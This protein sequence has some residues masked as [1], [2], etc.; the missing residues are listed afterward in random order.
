MLEDRACEW[1][2]KP[3]FWTNMSRWN[4]YLNDPTLTDRSQKMSDMK[5][6]SS[7]TRKPTQCQTQWTLCRQTNESEKV[8]LP[9]YLAS[10]PLLKLYTNIG[11]V[12]FFE[13]GWFFRFWSGHSEGRSQAQ[14]LKLSFERVSRRTIPRSFGILGQLWLEIGPQWVNEIQK[15][16][17]E[18]IRRIR[19]SGIGAEIGLDPN[20]VDSVT[21]GLL[22][23]RWK[24]E[25]R[26]MIDYKV[27][28][29]NQ[30]SSTNV[31]NTFLAIYRLKLHRNQ[32]KRMG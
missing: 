3:K 25:S 22:K 10:K 30:C 32:V 13:R 14:N 11:R 20:C 5:W 26:K 12:V 18:R 4:W 29:I 19:R 28:R 8:H 15:Y 6:G 21:V 23:Y 2:E 1:T 31:M 9:E 24:E 27:Y 17:N 7:I 16:F